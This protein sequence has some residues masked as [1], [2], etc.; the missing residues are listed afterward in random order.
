MSRT[1][2]AA[3]ALLAACL[4]AAC[5]DD[6]PKPDIPDPTPSAPTST[7]TAGSTSPTVSASPALGPEDTVKAWV[8]AW[9]GALR[10]GD[11]TAL[12][13]Y[14]TTDCRNCADLSRVIDDV[15]SAGGSFTGGAWAI[16]SSKVVEVNGHRDKVNV[17]MAVAE[18]STINA[19]GQD[20]VHFESDKRI[21]VY[22][23]EQ[24]SG[25]WLID[26]IELLS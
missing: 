14:E 13:Q 26:V 24:T 7:A 12:R 21:V 11:T 16:V 23:L 25:G 18:G 6:D 2:L 4:L 22:E 5:T 15:I 17:A 3:V 8:V 9:N 19:A 20:P 10:S 1:P